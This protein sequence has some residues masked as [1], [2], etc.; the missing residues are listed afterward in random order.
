MLRHLFNSF[1]LTA[2]HSGAVPVHDYGPLSAQVLCV[3]VQADPPDFSRI[4]AE[5]VVGVTVILLTCSYK[6]QVGR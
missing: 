5:D 1:T 4:P 6:S 3:C 2:K